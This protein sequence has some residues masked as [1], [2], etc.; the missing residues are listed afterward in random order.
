MLLKMKSSRKGCSRRLAFITLVSAAQ[1]AFAVGTDPNVT[2]ADQATGNTS[3]VAEATPTVALPAPVPPTSSDDPYKNLRW[4]GIFID[5]PPPSATIDGANNALRKTLAD[6]GIGYIG[7]WI[8]KMGDNLYSGAANSGPPTGTQRYFG[9]KFSWLTS[10]NADLFF[11]L[12]R[13]GIPDGQ[14]VLG[15]TFIKTNWEAGG[16][17]LLNLGALNYYQTLFNRRVELKAGYIGND[18]EFYGPYVAGNLSNAIFGT[19]GTVITQTGFS[20][21]LAPRPGANITLHLTDK[22]YNKFGVHAS[23]SPDGY[24][25]NHEDNPTGFDW[26]VPHARTMLIDEF[27]YKTNATPST[28]Q[29][30]WR[31]GYIHN[32]SEFKDFKYGGRGTGEYAWYVMA[33]QQ[34]YRFSTASPYRGVFA[35]F[36]VQKANQ[37]FTAISSTYELRLY[38]VGPFDS[39]PQD[40]YAIIVDRNGFSRYAQAQASNAGS[41]THPTSTTVTVAYKAAVYRGVYAGI[42]LIYT[43]NPTPVTYAPNTGHAVTA[44]ANIITFF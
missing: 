5:L 41:L 32:N 34:V 6:Y 19:S 10:G 11:D 15:G 44:L 14:I 43:N 33:D 12:S 24:V 13:Y 16:P 3:T 42:S 20:G 38:A 9:Q 39:R 18:Y 30:W 17:S 40:S 37:E 8:V 29:S 36:S 22:I 4:K 23:T 28:L 2:A 27:G 26:H 7:N 21:T 31:V 1:G 35:G 25:Q